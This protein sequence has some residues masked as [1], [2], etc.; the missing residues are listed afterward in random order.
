MFVRRLRL[1]QSPVRECRC[2]KGTVARPLASRKRKISPSNA[3]ASP[4]SPSS[5]SSSPAPLYDKLFPSKP[6]RAVE[7]PRASRPRPSRSHP[8]RPVPPVNQPSKLG[9]KESPHPPRDGPNEE[10]MDLSVGDQLRLWLE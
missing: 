9:H 8:S 10:A 1:P 5:P 6:A 7:R 3:A 2:H 4:S